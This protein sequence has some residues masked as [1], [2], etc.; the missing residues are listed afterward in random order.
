M[1]LGP[2]FG[3]QMELGRVVLAKALDSSQPLY[4]LAENFDWEK[5]EKSWSI[6]F[7]KVMGRTS[8]SPRLIAGLMIVS[9]KEGLSDEE[10]VDQFSQNMYYQFLCGETHFTH[11]RPCHPSLLSKWRRLVGDEGVAKLLE[12]TIELAKRLGVITNESIKRVIVDTTVMEKDIKYPKD[13]ELLE[14]SRSRMV[15]LAKKGGVD[16]NHTYNRKGPKLCHHAGRF[17]HKKKMDKFREILDE[18]RR[19]VTDMVRDLMRKKEYIV[20]IALKMETSRFCDIVER[21]LKAEKGKKIYSLHEPDVHVICKGKLR[22]PYEYGCKSSVTVTFQ[23][24]FIVGMQALEGAPYDGHTLTPALQ[25]VEDLTGVTPEEAYADAGYIGHKHETA[26]VYISGQTSGLTEQQKVDLKRR[27][28]VEPIIG[29]MKSEGRLA[30]CPLKG[31]IG[32]KIHAIL[33]AVAHN[34][35]K[36]IKEIRGMNK[37]SIPMDTIKC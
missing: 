29:H 21:L 7:S 8:K 3:E 19:I 16:L 13:Y 28:A 24:C 18:Q 10:V 32:D 25:Q 35:R 33:C 23:E 37:G 34:I 11:K 9:Y 17:L 15:E 26:T 27:S 4:K 2:I 31:I 6:H 5:L 22:N 12:E 30:R 36:L 20:D 1:S 14:R